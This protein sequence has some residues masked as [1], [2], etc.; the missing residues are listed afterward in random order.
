LW[1]AGKQVAADTWR[2]REDAV[3]FARRRR[4][5][6][7]AVVYPEALVLAEAMR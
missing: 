2:G 6:A 1:W 3:D 5:A 7:P 4:A